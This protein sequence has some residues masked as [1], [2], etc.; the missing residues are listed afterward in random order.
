MQDKWKPTALGDVATEV[1]D[2]VDNPSKSEFDHF[3]GLEH[4]ETGELT[5]RHRGSTKDVTSS[6]KIFRKG[7]ILFAR[8]NA[9]LKRASLAEFDGICSGD[10]LVL[11]HDPTKL[12]DRFLPVIFNSSSLW[13][14]AI[15][16]A[17]GSMSKRVKWRDLKKYV[18][19]LPPKE[20][21]ESISK[22]VW[23]AEDCVIK[24]EELLR[25]TAILRKSLRLTMF[26]RG[27][28]HAT[29]RDTELGKIPTNWGIMR[30]EEVLDLCQYGLSVKFGD[31]GKYPII[32]MDNFQNGMV[33]ANNVKRVDLSDT[34][35][36]NFKLEKGDILVNRTNTYELVGRTGIFLLD[37]DYTFA[38]YLIRIRPCKEIVNSSFLAFYL[39][40][41]SRRLKVLATKAVQQANINATNLKSLRIPIPPLE[42]QEE[43]VE[44][45]S[46]VDKAATDTQETIRTTNAVK[47]KLIDSLVAGDVSE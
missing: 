14:Y 27:L 40:S 30:L 44:I 3:V 43:I 37:G 9:Y 4:L 2:R 5:I 21:Q 25:E 47:M 36:K 39:I 11:R 20:E 13:S 46:L 33:T 29:L 16:H 34:V 15:S 23:T 19:P 24:N 42:E 10:A 6:M 12:A 7:D 17:S 31:T 32:K 26:C 8:R 18:F 38:S 28:R 45:L 35:F 41:F 22:K 1:L